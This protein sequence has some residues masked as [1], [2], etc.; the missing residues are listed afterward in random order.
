MMTF[1][2]KRSRPTVGAAADPRHAMDGAAGGDAGDLYDPAFLAALDGFSLRIAEA[3]KGGRLA[4][5]RTSARGQGADFADFRSYAAGDDLRTID[6]NLYRRLGKLFVRVFEEQQDLPVYLLIDVS[7]SMYA[8][9]PRRIDA[10]RRVALGLASV[11]LRQHDAVTVLP[12]SDDVATTLRGVNGKAN[13][14]RVARALA[15]L[16]PGGGTELAAVIRQLAATRMRRGL[17]VII[18]DFFDDEGI[19]NTVAVLRTLRHRLLLVQ[20]VRAHDADP[21]LD[22]AL[23]GDVTLQ[24]DETAEGVALT[25]TPDLVAAYLR[26]YRGFNRQLHEFADGAAV[27]LMRIDAGDD[28][29]AQMTAFFAGGKMPS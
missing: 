10:A 13:V 15:T 18:S 22:P 11:A 9:T 27:G 20:M 14:A 23:T 4:D 29:L 21:A 12:F 26:A 5:Q 3:Q 28:V 8:E 19:G 17:L 6:W 25:I 24:D 2:W 16:R 7:R 1:G